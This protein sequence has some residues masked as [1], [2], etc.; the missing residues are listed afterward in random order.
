VSELA[1]RRT[2]EL[3]AMRVVSTLELLSLIVIVTNRLT[4]HESAVTSVGGPLHGLLYL[5]TIVLA[6]LLPFPRSARWLSVLPG[7]GGLLA[8][9]Q[10]RRVPA[11][12][13]V[14]SDERAQADE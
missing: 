7:V 3:T 13:W 4:V 5:A 6:L 12:E 10:A 2:V 9:W 1:A 8:V 11:D 14:R